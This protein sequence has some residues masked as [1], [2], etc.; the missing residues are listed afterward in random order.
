MAEEFDAD[1]PDPSDLGHQSS[2]EEGED[3]DIE[4]LV[5]KELEQL[6]SSTS[7]KSLAHR[8]NWKQMDCECC[9]PSST[10]V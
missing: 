10:L 4:S 1:A 9:E 7:A 6:K 2:D 5:E 3:Q 8:F